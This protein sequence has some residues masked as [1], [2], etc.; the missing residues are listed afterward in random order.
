MFLYYLIT[1]LI[2]YGKL[3]ILF[4]IK[5]IRSSKQRKNR[6]GY[7]EKIFQQKSYRGSTQPISPKEMQLDIIGHCTFWTEKKLCK[8]CDYCKGFIQVVCEK[9]VVGFATT[10]LTIVLKF[11]M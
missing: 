1:V 9:C 3:E 5:L 6:K 4:Y 2:I 10:K 7:I 8:Y 11:F